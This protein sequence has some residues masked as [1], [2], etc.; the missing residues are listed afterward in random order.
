MLQPI[1]IVDVNRIDSVIIYDFFDLLKVL[2]VDLFNIKNDTIKLFS[3]NYPLLQQVKDMERT[4]E[5]GHN[6]DRRIYSI[7]YRVMGGKHYGLNS[8]LYFR[9]HRSNLDTLNIQLEYF[10]EWSS[11]SR[12]LKD[13]CISVDVT[14]EDNTWYLVDSDDMNIQRLNSEQLRFKYEK[15]L[16]EQVNNIIWV[17]ANRR[18]IASKI[19]E[20]GDYKLLKDIELL[21]S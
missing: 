15:H 14:Y 9:L 7:C 16:P 2:K 20:I 6:K 21:L 11:T 1:E 13:T 5:Y 3:L 8:D 10:K 19:S 12:S 4:W 17:E 18:G